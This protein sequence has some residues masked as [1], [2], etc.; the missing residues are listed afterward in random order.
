MSTLMERTFCFYLG[1]GVMSARALTRPWVS[2]LLGMSP[3][4]PGTVVITGGSRGLGF[5]IAREYV[6]R[7]ARVAICARDVAALERALHDLKRRAHREEDVMVLTCDVTDPEQVDT[8]FAEVRK[9]FGPIDVL[10]NNAGVMTVGPEVD[11]T[12]EDYEEALNVH[13]WGPLHTIRS[14]LPEMRRRKRGRI[15]NIASIGG[16]VAVPH[17]L[18]YCA[19]KHA[20]AGL[21]EGMRAELAKDG[22]SVTTVSP[23]LMRTGSTLNARFKGRHREEYAWVSLSGSTPGLSISVESAARRIVSAAALRRPD[24]VLTAP[25]R[26]MSAFHGLF[27]GM[28]ARLLGEVDQ[29]LLPAPNGAGRKARKGIES[30]SEW[31]QGALNRPMRRAAARANQ[32]PAEPEPHSSR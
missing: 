11:M 3:E 1:A 21:S 19:S 16:R 7:R 9:R 8:M 32:L 30:E 27:P 24:L 25:A 15:V 13:F 29:R 10:V 17:L 5:A 31:T 18:P 6:R 2:S 4:G 28:T 22:V 23:G 14:V 20:L 26:W 12:K